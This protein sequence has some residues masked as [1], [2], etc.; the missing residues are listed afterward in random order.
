MSTKLNFT[1]RIDLDPSVIKAKIFPSALQVGEYEIS[2]TADL[3]SVPLT[4]DFDVVFLYKA[5]G[6]TKR[7]EIK[8]QT[9][10]KVE[11]THSLQ[12]MRKPL[13]VEIDV[14]VV[15]M[16]SKLI[17]IIRASIKRVIPEVPDKQS[18]RSSALK[19]K[20]DSDLNVPWRLYFSEE[21]PI[22]HVSDKHG[23]YDQLF[24]TPQFDPL[25]LSDVTRQIFLWL[26]FDPSPKDQYFVGIWKT[27]FES[28][29]CEQAFFD[30]LPIPNEEDGFMENMTPAL[31]E[32]VIAMS[33]QV[34]DR[35]TANLDLLNRLANTEIGDE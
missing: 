32:E 11:V 25:I 4:G 6:E 33:I 1:N 26:V 35:L 15:Q 19:T 24:S 31:R 14:K 23:L 10:N 22:L 8:N 28:L 7:D 29:G 16:D 12:G 13:E 2:I 30:P 20:K 27:I 3:S 5:I 34:S 17:P 9:G 21:Y 18:A